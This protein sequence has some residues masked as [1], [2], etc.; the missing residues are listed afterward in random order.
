VHFETHP[1]SNEGS[2]RRVDRSFGRKLKPYY[3]EVVQTLPDVV[4][5]FLDEKPLMALPGVSDIRRIYVPEMVI[6]LH[7]VHVEAGN[8]INKGLLMNALE[9]AADVA[10]PAK[11]ILDTFKG[12]GR[13]E[14]YVEELAAASRSILGA[15]Q[16][17]TEGL[18]IW[19]V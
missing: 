9:L 19:A 10:D 5:T 8:T 1:D 12:T 17:G 11:N 2:R 3:E 13:L 14:E 18:G 4:K 6:S 7:R 16:G 15:A